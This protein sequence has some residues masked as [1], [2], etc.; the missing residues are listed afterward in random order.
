MPDNDPGQ[1]EG[2][3]PTKGLTS[4][5]AETYSLRPGDTPALV[6]KR[7]KVSQARLVEVNAITDPQKLTVGQTLVIPKD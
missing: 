6:A 4:A 7:F 5:E 2:A 1:P 3:L